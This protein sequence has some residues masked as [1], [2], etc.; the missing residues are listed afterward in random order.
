MSSKQQPST[1][2]VNGNHLPIGIITLLI[3]IAVCILAT[4]ES[5]HYVA[6]W[7]LA[8]WMP[9]SLRHSIQ[10]M[11]WTHWETSLSPSL[12]SAQHSSGS[13][14]EDIPSVN[15]QEHL[16]DLLPHLEKTFGKNWRRRPLLLQN[17]WTK[18]QLNDKNRR[19]S[20][21]GLLEE[22][23]V[24]PYF[25]NATRDDAL[26]PDGKARVCDVVANISRGGPQKIGT[27]LLV[28]T[29]PE[30]VSEVAPTNLLTTLWGDYFQPHHVRGTGPFGV[31]PALTTVPVFVA[32]GSLSSPSV[33]DDINPGNGAALNNNGE[34][35]RAYT[36]LHC[37]PIGNVAVQLSGRKQWILVQPEYSLL[38]RPSTSPDGRAFF[39]SWSKDYMDRVPTYTTITQAGDAIWVP[40]SRDCC[41]PSYFFMSVLK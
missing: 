12:S 8:Q 7:A 18:S 28:Q 16:D 17:L 2:A 27:Q 41:C 24:I 6:L 4:I 25:T 23:L 36:A 9:T 26:T 37:E 11:T 3:A 34:I 30:L 14:N 21:N 10:L 13:L 19:I 22:N 32:S 1:I 40:V 38:I 33:E 20:L 31:F 15:V 35:K 29:F 5:A 39:A